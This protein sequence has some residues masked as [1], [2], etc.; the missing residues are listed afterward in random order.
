MEN[1]HV[2]TMTDCPLCKDVLKHFEAMGTIPTQH[3]IEDLMTG[4]DA[5]DD[6]MVQL[7]MQD[8]AAPVVQVNGKFLDVRELMTNGRK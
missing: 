2:W 7:V 5:N 8:Y 6:V 4:M 1:A 3:K